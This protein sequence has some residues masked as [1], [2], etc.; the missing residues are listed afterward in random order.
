MRVVNNI[1]VPGTV[2]GWM[3][4]A[5]VRA[6]AARSVLAGSPRWLGQA[7]METGGER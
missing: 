6:H 4:L 3:G 5:A 2:D 1:R 7:E